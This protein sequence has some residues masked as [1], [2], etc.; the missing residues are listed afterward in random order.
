VRVLWFALFS[1]EDMIILDGMSLFVTRNLTRF[2]SHSIPYL[3][4]PT[5]ASDNSDFDG[6]LGLYFARHVRIYDHCVVTNN[7]MHLNV[8]VQ[9]IGKL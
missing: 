6:S 4:S 2:S 9:T 1:L 3:L 7:C 5:L 8:Y